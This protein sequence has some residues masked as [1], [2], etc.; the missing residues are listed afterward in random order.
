MPAPLAHSVT[1]TNTPYTHTNPPTNTHANADTTSTT[2]EPQ[3]HA[4]T[5]RHHNARHLTEHSWRKE[6][7]HRA[8]HQPAIQLRRCE[9]PHRPRLQTVLVERREWHTRRRQRVDR[10]VHSTEHRV[11]DKRE[12]S[13]EELQSQ[14]PDGMA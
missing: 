3:S 4:A 12:E 11:H 7:Q 10:E 14:H 1:H 8:Q 13:L 6:V 2:T 5:A 9:P